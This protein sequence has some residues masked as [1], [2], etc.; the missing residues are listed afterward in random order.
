MLSSATSRRHGRGTAVV[1]AATLLLAAGA[2]PASAQSPSSDVAG[3]TGATAVT[4]TVNLPGGQATR[5]VLTLDPVTGTASRVGPTTA[6]LG[7][8]EVLTGSVGAQAMGTGASEAKLPAPL[9]VTTDP[10]APFNAGLAGSPLADL[11]T[12]RLAPS[13]ASVTAAPSSTSAASVAEAWV[14]PPPW[15]T[16]WRHCSTPSRRGSTPC[17]PRWPRRPGRRSRSCAPG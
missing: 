6:A 17:S 7:R 14:C 11:L 3:A 2:V 15:Q 1:T 9:T 4:V 8:S 10:A 5:L 12:V 16:G 13:T